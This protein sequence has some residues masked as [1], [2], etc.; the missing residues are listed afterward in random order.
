MKILVLKNN[1]SNQTVLDAG[2]A[3]VKTECPFLNLEFTEMEFNKQLTSLPFS[4]ATNK[5]GYYVNPTDLTGTW[6]IG[7]N[8]LICIYDWSKIAP[9]PT[10][11]MDNTA[12]IQIPEQ[13]YIESTSIPPERVLCDFIEHEL[14][15]LEAS[16]RGVP[17]ITH[18]LVN[19]TLNPFLYAQFASKQPHEWYVYYLEQLVGYT[20]LPQ[21]T[22][23]RYPQEHETTGVLTTVSGQTSFSCK[24]L[25]LPWLDNQPNVSCIP[26]G[27]YT[28]KWMHTLRFPFGV[29]QVQNVPNRSGIDIHVGNY[30]YGPKIDTDGC[31]L[32]GDSFVNLNG[33]MSADIANSTKTVTAFNA[34]LNKQDFT[35][36]LE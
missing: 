32:L 36:I 24:T 29:Y 19:M 17:D 8:A 14:C 21:V 31:I 3:L 27:T 11:P 23:K 13:W 1:L 22:I 10:N 35:L 33:D 34:L 12:V 18:L 30:A 20:S 28:V 2:L 25:E 9:Q 5:N 4:N 15:H 26:V 6:D 7:Y 16:E